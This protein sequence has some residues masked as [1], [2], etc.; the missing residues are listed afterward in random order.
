VK[1]RGLYCSK[2]PLEAPRFLA[3]GGQALLLSRNTTAT[4]TVVQSKCFAGLTG[5][6]SDQ[7][8]SALQTALMTVQFT[9]ESIDKD[10]KEPKNAEKDIEGLGLTRVY[11]CETA[12]AKVAELT[13]RKAI[14]EMGISVPCWKSLEKVLPSYIEYYTKLGNE[15]CPTPFPTPAP[16][17]TNGTN[18]SF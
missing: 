13:E 4:Q 5:N 11:C 7:L 17:A 18:G 6:S 9:P 10:C 14:C 1:H 2:R 16:N 15:L 3:L 8:C 12:K